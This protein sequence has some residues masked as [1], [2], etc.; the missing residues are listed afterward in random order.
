MPLLVNNNTASAK[1]ESLFELEDL[2][3]NTGFLML[4]VSNLWK[5]YHDKVLKKCHGLSHIQYAVLAGISF[6]H[7]KKPISQALIAQHSRIDP[8]IVSQTFKQLE[9]KRYISYVSHPADAGEEVIALTP[10]GEELVSQVL[11]TIVETDIKFFKSLG[12]NAGS[13]NNY[14]KTLLEVN[15]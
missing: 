3:R 7:N 11:G 12:E 1:D 2:E 13:F 8:M 5:E 9:N 4:Q 14:L 10:K 6:Y 15:D